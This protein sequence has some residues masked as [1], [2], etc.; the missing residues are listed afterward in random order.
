MALDARINNIVEKVS[1]WSDIRPEGP[2]DFT[3]ATDQCGLSVTSRR[4]FKISGSFR[5][6]YGFENDSPLC[7]AEHKGDYV[8]FPII[9]SQYLQI[10]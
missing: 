8:K 5:S 6:N 7:S 9:C 10:L 1:Y 2:T 3:D 4:I